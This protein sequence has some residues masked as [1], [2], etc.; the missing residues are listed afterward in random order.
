MAKKDTKINYVLKGVNLNTLQFTCLLDGQYKSKKGD[1]V[2]VYKDDYKQE[3]KNNDSLEHKAEIVINNTLPDG[4]K[5]PY[6]E[7]IKAIILKLWK[8]HKIP[9]NGISCLKNGDKKAEELESREKNGDRLLNTHV[10]KVHSKFDIKFFDKYV[11]PYEPEEDTELNGKY[12]NA[13]L[14]F[15]NYDRG[16]NKGVT[17]FVSKI[18]VFDQ[19]PAFEF[20]IR[21]ED[22]FDA[23]EFGA[24]EKEEVLQK[25]VG[26]D[27]KL[28]QG[29][30]VGNDGEDDSPFA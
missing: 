23:V 20:D 18:Q 10:L 5:N 1:F 24:D 4:S 25:A 7:E 3:L 8:E 21:A 17:C 2:R 13:V 27:E 28:A 15:K 19:N 30:P 29:I 14:Q 22:A 16:T 12:I 9:K 6:L 11:R 26:S